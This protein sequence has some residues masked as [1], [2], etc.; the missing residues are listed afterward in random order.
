[1]AAWAHSF[2]IDHA[3]FR[4]AWSNLGTVEPGVLYRSNHPTPFQLRRAVRAL[5]LKSVINLRGDGRTGTDA[6]ARDEARRIGLVQFDIGLESRGAP[7]AED[8]L[9]LVEVFRTMPRPALMHCKSGADRTGLAAGVW[10]M[11]H[12]GAA[13]DA[14]AQLTLRHGHINRSNTGILDAFFHQ[15]AVQAEGRIGFF[16]W[17]VSEYDPVALRA[18]F[19]G[20]GSLASFVNDRLLRRE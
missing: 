9:R 8:I 11:L 16:D 20:A 17:L 6:L 12:G 14:L 19:R 5:G 3:F 7:K 2:F 1:M 13:K 15:Y 10:V 18:N 4:L